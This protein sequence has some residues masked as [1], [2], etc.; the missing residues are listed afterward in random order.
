MSQGM[1]SAYWG[2][3]AQRSQ[4]QVLDLYYKITAAKT[5]SDSN[6]NVALTAFDAISSQSVI[7]DFLGTTDEFLLAAFD[8]TAMGADAFAAIVQMG[9]QVSE[10]ICAKA[11]CY[12][13]TDGATVVSQGVASVATLTAST[14]STQVAKGAYG[15][16]AI[17]VAF[18]N[19]PDFDA[20]TAGL[21][22]LQIMYRMK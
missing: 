21:I 17:R 9:G 6:K 20:L 12:S 10:V 13:G 4:V 3:K 8:A 15:N 7:N 2:D 18:G 14:L 19:T 5:V 16:V 11:L 22:H 1:S